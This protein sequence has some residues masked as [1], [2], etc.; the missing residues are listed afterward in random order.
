VNSPSDTLA[1]IQK[2]ARR[3]SPC[4][5]RDLFSSYLYDDGSFAYS[6]PNARTR[7]QSSN[8]EHMYTRYETLGD[9]NLRGITGVLSRAV[10]SRRLSGYATAA[11]FPR[12]PGTGLARRR[13]STLGNE[14]NCCFVNL[15][16]LFEFIFL[17]SA[18]R[19]AVRGERAATHHSKRE[20]LKRRI[21]ARIEQPAGSE[22]AHSQPV[23]TFVTYTPVN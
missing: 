18:I 5:Q 14:L 3:V 4:A 16:S 12:S 21:G 6:R 19:G 11:V 22:P 9:L 20:A 10:D 1:E 13:G 7:R 15:F 2:A 23:I 8:F 17:R